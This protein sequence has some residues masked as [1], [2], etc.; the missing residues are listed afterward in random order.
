MKVELLRF[1][2]LRFI[3][4]QLKPI[5]IFML[6]IFHFPMFRYFFIVVEFPTTNKCSAVGAN[7][8]NHDPENLQSTS[9]RRYRLHRV[10]MIVNQ[11]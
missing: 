6:G 11:I 10:E 8:L 7:F 4:A 1:I 9:H 2:N 5:K 3:A